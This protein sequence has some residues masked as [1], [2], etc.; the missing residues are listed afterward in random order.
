MPTGV[1]Q[2]T[3]EWKKLH[4]EI[5]KGKHYSP[6]TE[7]KKGNPA[8]KTAF[9]KGNKFWLNKKRP[10]ISNKNNPN[11]KGGIQRSN[12]RIFILMP[13][14]PFATKAGYIRHSRLIMEKHLGRYLKPEE[15]VHH[16]NGIKND[17]RIENLQLF[18]NRSEH[19]RFH[20]LYFSY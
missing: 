19:A 1:Y 6:A 3:M 18:V 9:K 11:W 7:F 14:H 20:R 8:P 2:R 16:I 17:D 4:S 12:G 13:I 5:R 10:N 15:V